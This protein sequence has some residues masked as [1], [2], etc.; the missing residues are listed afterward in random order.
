MRFTIFE[1]NNTRGLVSNRFREMY[2]GAKGDL[3]LTNE[4]GGVTRYHEGAFRNYGMESGIPSSVVSA[5]TVSEA[6]EVWIL[7]ANSILQ[8]NQASGKFITVMPPQKV[9]YGLLQWD[10]SGFWGQ[11][12]ARIHCFVHGHFVDYTLPP[13]LARDVVWGAAVDQDGALW[14]ETMDGRQSK[15]GLDGT[16]EAVGHG[17]H[18]VMNLVDSQGR[19]WPMRVG[20]PPLVETSTFNLRVKR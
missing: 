6:G 1:K 15:I 12:G 3:W 7:S 9:I 2:P 17:G 10:I 8:W 16:S 4:I 14:L 5:L 13:W 19:A 11:D 18:A 20:G